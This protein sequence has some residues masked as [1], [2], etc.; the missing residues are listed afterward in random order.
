MPFIKSFVPKEYFDEVATVLPAVALVPEAVRPVA[1]FPQQRGQE[2]YAV[3][4]Q[5]TT[6]PLSDDFEDELFVE[7]V[8]LVVVLDLEVTT[9]LFTWTILSV[10]FLTTF[11]ETLFFSISVSF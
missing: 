11:S 7:T 8:S 2:Q 5:M 9:S 10:G 4:L 3:T 1:P 6:D